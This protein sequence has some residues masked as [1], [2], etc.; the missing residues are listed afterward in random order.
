MK[1]LLI[2]L[3]LAAMLIGGSTVAF[4]DITQSKS[5]ENSGMKSEELT[6]VLKKGLEDP[7]IVPSGEESWVLH[8]PAEHRRQ[9]FTVASSEE[10]G[11]NQKRTGD[12]RES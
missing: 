1:N 6:Q 11:V 2:S 5:D 9:Y 4:A 10:M 3:V 8:K 12:N 7:I